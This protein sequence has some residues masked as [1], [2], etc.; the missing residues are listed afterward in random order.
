MNSNH[1]LASFAR[2]DVVDLILELKQSGYDY[3]S[4]IEKLHEQGICGGAVLMGFLG[5]FDLEIGEAKIVQCWHED[6]TPEQEADINSSFEIF[7]KSKS[8]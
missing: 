8:S 1:I 3:V 7:I 5:A 2:A 4:I 6:L